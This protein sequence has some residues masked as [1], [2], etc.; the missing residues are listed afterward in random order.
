MLVKRF[1]PLVLL[2]LIIIFGAC[3]RLVNLPTVPPSLFSDEIDIAYQ[4]TS[5]KE[6]GKDYS[7]YS[8]PL[9]I[10]SLSD[11]RT[12]LPIYTTLLVSLIP[13]ID[14]DFAV[15][16]TPA[17]FGVLGIIATYLLVNQLF[18]NKKPLL[19][20]ISA[21]L[22]SITPW[23]FHYSRVGFEVSGLYFFLSLGLFL[24]KYYL[25][26][27]KRTQYLYLSL[28][29]L[30]LLPLIY[31]TGK[32]TVI[33]LPLIILILVWPNINIYRQKKFIVF[34]LLLFLPLICLMINGGAAKR[35]S[36]IAVH[37]DPTI[38]TEVD[39]NRKVAL[40]LNPAV[41]S[42]PTLISKLA[43]NKPVYLIRR[44]ID[45]YFQ[46]IGTDF[47]FLKG[48]PNPRHSVP[49]Y[50]VL[51]L[52]QGFLMLIG[53]CTF[54]ASWRKNKQNIFILIILFFATTLPA[55]ITRDGGNH[56]TRLFL[57]LLPIIIISSEALYQIFSRYRLI[58][59]LLILLLSAESFLY[60]QNY[61][62]KYPLE[63][64]RRWHAGIKEI[65]LAS[66]KYPNKTIIISPRYEPPLIFYLYYSH[67][68]PQ[69]F[70]KLV[71]QDSFFH[72][73]DPELNL[74]GRQFDSKNVYFASVKEKK[75]NAN[76]IFLIHN[77]VYYIN[78]EEIET[79]LSLEIATQSATIKLP[80]G[81]PL[82]YEYQ[83]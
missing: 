12:P 67:F 35:F 18:P 71:K 61:F 32:L 68:P 75:G 11:I 3:L 33:F 9:Q 73:I 41:G 62:S 79:P 52:T 14:L 25:D 60:F 31:S 81:E 57:L 2:G 20:I 53:L 42:S 46:I 55:A 66:Q 37:T 6:T 39:Y 43:H 80:S 45:N 72:D 21:F 8:W 15:R 49:N 63:S 13:G 34:N 40:G 19:G 24:F 48:D 26:N 10:H 5:L 7:G 1:L 83:P 29:F 22:I 74:E 54:F 64:E 59:I 38:S 58:G 82:F 51:H 65:I 36:E 30:S 4:V 78:R 17:I 69:E 77:A 44:Y 70:Q 23:H 50:G 76:N 56:A 16:L 47:L 28:I 27:Q